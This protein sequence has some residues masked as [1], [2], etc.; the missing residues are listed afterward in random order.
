MSLQVYFTS[1]LDLYT[2]EQSTELYFRY[3]ALDHYTKILMWNDT[4]K[5]IN[6]ENNI[7]GLSLSFLDY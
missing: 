3:P 7:F 5:I 1:S 4:H 6:L 2:I